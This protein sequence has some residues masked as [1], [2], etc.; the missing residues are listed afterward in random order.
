MKNILFICLICFVLNYHEGPAANPKHQGADYT[1][2]TF[3]IHNGENWLDD[4]IGEMPIGASDCVDSFLYDIVREKYYDRCCYIRLQVNGRMH[5]GCIEL[6][7]EDYLDIAETIRKIED[8]D[9]KY[10]S[11]VTKDSKVYQLDC[12]SSYLKIFSIVIALFALI[13]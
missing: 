13:F 5:A 9:K 1:C 10:I 7:E 12:A 6:R 11:S 8:G 2:R 4:M 3:S